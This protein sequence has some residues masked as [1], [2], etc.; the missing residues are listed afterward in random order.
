[1]IQ[2]IL[3]IKKQRLH[4]TDKTFKKR[5]ASIIFSTLLMTAAVGMLKK[6]TDIYFPDWI[7][8]EQLLKFGL[9]TALISVG[10]IVFTVFVLISGGVD[11][12][13]IKSRLHRKK[14]G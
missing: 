14:T 7:H 10:G 6:E 3:R 5:T 9:L 4:Q 13:E 1:M 2:Y 12:K 8:G 11:L